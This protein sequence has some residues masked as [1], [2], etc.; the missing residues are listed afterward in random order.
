MTTKSLNNSLGLYPDTSGRRFP[1]LSG[2]PLLE[3]HHLV[4]FLLQALLFANHVS[5][6]Y[7]LFGIIR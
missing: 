3:S 5:D 2:P 6:L 1:D 7:S 4:A